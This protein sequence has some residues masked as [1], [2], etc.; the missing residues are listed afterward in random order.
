MLGSAKQL[1][2]DV[3]RCG[4]SRR[5][6]HGGFATLPCERPTASARS[7]QPNKPLEADLAA[8]AKSTQPGRLTGSPARSLG[9]RRTTALMNACVT[10]CSFA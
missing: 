4:L 3:S 7:S 9:A 2:L 1:T 8:T 5:A 6:G 10:S